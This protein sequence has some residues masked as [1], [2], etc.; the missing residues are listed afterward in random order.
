MTNIKV[1]CKD[2][3]QTLEETIY[4]ESHPS[5]PGEKWIHSECNGKCLAEVEEEVVNSDTDMGILS[6]LYQEASVREDIAHHLNALFVYASSV[7]TITE[8]GTGSGAAT[9]A[10]AFGRPDRLLTVDIAES[11][12]AR[13]VCDK[14]KAAGINIEYVIVSSLDINLE[15]VDFLFIDTWHTHDQLAAELERHHDKAQKFLGFHDMNTFGHI[16]EDGGLGM[17]HAL[18]DFLREHPE[19]IIN[20]HSPFCNGLTI[21]RRVG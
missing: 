14:I 8:L 6:T 13:P 3:G 12:L 1:T 9:A 15:P 2:C 21:L 10:F 5:Y 11:T 18:G 19:W 20:E 7:R 17:V 4:P 16:G